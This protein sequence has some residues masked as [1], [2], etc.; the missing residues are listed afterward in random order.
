MLHVVGFEFRD[1]KDRRIKWRL[2]TKTV[3]NG[4]FT[5]SATVIST[6]LNL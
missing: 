6:V 1:F 3:Q 5:V 2:T 4:V